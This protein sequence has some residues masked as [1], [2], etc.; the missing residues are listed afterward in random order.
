MAVAESGDKEGFVI[1]GAE[2]EE[3]A[4]VLFSGADKAGD[5]SVEEGTVLRLRD[6][7]VVVPPLVDKVLRGGIK[8]NRR[9]V[10]LDVDGVGSK[11]AFDERGGFGHKCAQLNRCC[12]RMIKSPLIS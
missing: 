8:F 11:G 10:P 7:E 9:G 2:G 4:I 12:F 3:E 1:G 5:G 6:G